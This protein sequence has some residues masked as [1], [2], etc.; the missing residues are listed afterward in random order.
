MSEDL[1]TSCKNKLLFFSPSENTST[2]FTNSL[3]YMCEHKIDGSMGVIINRPINVMTIDLL[4]SLEIE[5]KS[6]PNQK[7]LLMGGPVNPGAVF[8][9][10]QTKQNWDST[11]L[12]NK[13][14][15]ISTSK[16]ILEAIATEKGPENYLI[17]LG[18]SGWSEGQ[19]DEE[20]SENTWITAPANQEIIFNTDPEEMI[21]AVS[22]E[23]GFNLQMVSPDYGSG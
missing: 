16:D 5:I 11:I 3:I 22:K 21:K 18:Y 14:I 15:S 10:H 6:E 2:Y 13:D 17:T 8:V 1:E 20:L 4:N 19:L 23:V 9:L 12:I 7:R